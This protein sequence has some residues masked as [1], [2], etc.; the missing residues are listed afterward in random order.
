MCHVLVT[1]PVKILN[2]YM[3]VIQRRKIVGNDGFSCMKSD[4]FKHT[5]ITSFNKFVKIQVHI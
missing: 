4:T 1:E 3:A 2:E 5:K